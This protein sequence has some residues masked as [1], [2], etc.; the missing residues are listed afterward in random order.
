MTAALDL[1]EQYKEINAPSFISYPVEADGKFSVKLVE[2]EQD[3]KLKS[4]TVTGVPENTILIHLHTFSRLDI[5]SPMKAVV[6]SGIGAFRC[7]DYLILSEESGVLRFVYVELKSRT[8]DTDEIV[9]QFKGASCFMAYC[10]AI[11]DHFQN[12][13]SV[14]KTTIA[15]MSYVLLHWRNMNKRGT[16]R[17]DGLKRNKYRESL[18][19]EEHIRI[20]AL[21]MNGV[22][23]Y[24]LF[25]TSERQ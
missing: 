11:V 5:G 24:S 13:L 12:M 15:H 21:D 19:P 14:R 9:G 1:L 17:R 18:L 6:K 22:V 2:A 3:A 23:Q 25:S 7:C 10:D 4:V 8:F 16:A 20:S